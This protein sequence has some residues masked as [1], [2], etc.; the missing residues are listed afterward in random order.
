MKKYSK[1]II[2]FFICLCMSVSLFAGVSAFA[3]T[4]PRLVDEA[5]LLTSEEELKLIDML[6]SISDKVACDVVVITVDDMGGK[7]AQ[8]FADDYMDYNG[9]GYNG[10]EDCV[11]LAVGMAEREY[12][13]STRGFAID[14][15]T[16]DAVENMQDVLESHL[17]YDEYYDA[18]VEFAEIS[19]SYI[20]SARNGEYY[21][22]PFSVIGSLIT[23]LIIGFVVGIITVSV[24]KGQLK[25]VHAKTNA[26]D[27]EK[28]GSMQITNSKD[29]Y[30]YRTVTKTPKPKD[31][32]SGG[33]SH[34]S[35]SGRSHGGGG[36]RF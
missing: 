34:V 17:G 20:S 29:I 3:A 18:F 31:N 11:L 33:G 28:Q 21:K 4:D 36:G 30:L 15:F 24:F 6:D 10:G 35:S 27:Y 1:F 19:D 5:D 2:A 23:A 8:A 22:E 9:Y 12:H 25:S 26:K 32:S 14:A 7:T 13:F 16:D